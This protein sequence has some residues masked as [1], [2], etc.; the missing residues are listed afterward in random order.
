MWEF[1]AA[2]IRYER[3]A[4]IL[5]IFTLMKNLVYILSTLLVAGLL[6]FRYTAE[7]VETAEGEK[8]EWLSLEEAYKRNQQEPRKIFIDVYTDWCG[9]CKKM[10]KDTFSQ[11]EVAEYVNKNYY[12]VKLNAESSKAHQ[13]G[14]GKLTEQQAAQQWGVRSLPTIVLMEEDFKTIV[15]VG[16]Y[17]KPKDFLKMLEGFR[18]SNQN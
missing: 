2:Y 10:D 18:T 11:A 1:L 12:A 6:S 17:K 3:V 4:K 13:L 7:E 16:G 14:K 9:W 15:P 5:S 8:I